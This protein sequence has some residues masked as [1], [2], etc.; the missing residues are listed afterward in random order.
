M[1]TDRAATRYLRTL[2]VAEWPVS[3]IRVSASFQLADTSLFLG[4]AFL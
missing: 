4:I 2:E 3:F 1:K